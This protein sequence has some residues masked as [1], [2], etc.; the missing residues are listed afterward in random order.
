MM[1]PPPIAVAAFDFDGTITRRDSLVPF[2]GSVVGR[3]RLATGLAMLLPMLIGY[4]LEI[5][6]VAAAKE[7]LLRRFLA[8]MPFVALSAAAETFARED[9]PQLVRA[10][11]I[12]RLRWHQRQGHRCLLVTASLEVYIRPWAEKVGFDEVIASRL[13][14]DPHGRVTGRLAGVHCYGVEKARLVR[15]LLKD[16]GTYTL[17][18]YGDSQGDR[19]LLACAQHAYYRVMPIV[20]TARHAHR[21][22]AST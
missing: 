2:V 5:I 19:A 21:A 1:L 10:D 11:A 14:V 3:R 22:G 9:L 13:E 16:A 8:G 15:E 4:A 20:D 6:P 12:A 7:R 17:Y 18:A